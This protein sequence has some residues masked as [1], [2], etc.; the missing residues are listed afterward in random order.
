MLPRERLLRLLRERPDFALRLL[1]AMHGELR[2]SRA[3]IQEMGKSSAEAKICALLWDLLPHLRDTPSTEE[4]FPLAHSDLAEILGLS[5]ETI[6][7]AVGG[8]ARRG[9]VSVSHRHVHVHDPERL[10]QLAI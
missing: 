9:V 1:E 10:R 8:L 7:R 2:E 3:R 4:S 5:R 6:S